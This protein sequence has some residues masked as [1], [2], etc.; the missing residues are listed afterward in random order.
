MQGSYIIQEAIFWYWC[1]LEEKIGNG[2]DLLIY[3][4]FILTDL[5]D[6]CGWEALPDDPS[7]RATLA[8]AVLMNTML[9]IISLQ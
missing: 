8:K 1:E 4:R 9:L 6:R 5:A 7:P 3:F 2:C